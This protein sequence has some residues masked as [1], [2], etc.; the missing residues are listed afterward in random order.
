MFIPG[1]QCLLATARFLELTTRVWDVVHLSGGVVP[2]LTPV[3]LT[4]HA[5]T[6]LVLLVRKSVYVVFNNLI[7]VV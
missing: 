3:P 7:E 4:V 5:A 2:K 6:L 1:E